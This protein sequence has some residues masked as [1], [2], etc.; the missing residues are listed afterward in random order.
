[1][2]IYHLSDEAFFVVDAWSGILGVFRGKVYGVHGDLYLFLFLMLRASTITC[3]H[4]RGPGLCI[5]IVSSLLSF[6]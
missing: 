1:M 3:T 4:P 2:A 6:L 5:C